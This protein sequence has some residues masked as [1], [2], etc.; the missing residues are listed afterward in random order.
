MASQPESGSGAG[1]E[2]GSEAL[3]TVIAR[4][5]LQRGWVTRQQIVQC[6]R[7][8]GAAAPDR[9]GGTGLADLLVSKGLISRPQ[10]AIVDGEA[11]RLIRAGAY[12]EA[13]QEAGLGD[14]LVRMG[15][16]TQS[17]VQ[18]ALS[19]Q[20]EYA[21]RRELVP[22]LGEILLQ[23]G[24]V[25]SAALDEALRLQRTMTRLRCEYCATD[26][27]LAEFD[28]GKTYLCRGCASVL[29]RPRG[30][31]AARAD[32]PE[33]AQRAATNPKNVVGKY[34]AVKELG[35]GGMGAVYKA[36]D[37]VLKRWAALKILAV[38]GGPEAV[39]RFRREAETASQ[40]VHPNIVP[41][42]DVGEAGGYHYIAMQYIDGRQLGEQ[43]LPV[44]QACN[45]IIQVAR[46]IELAH[47][48]D[49]VHRDIK[50]QNILI[51]ASGR[52]YVTD[53]GLAKNLFESFNI[54]APGTVMGS[55]SY[56]SPEQAAGQVSKVDQRS[57]VYSLGALLFTLLTGRPPYKAET[58]VMTVR[59]VLE[60]PIPSPTEFNPEIPPELERIVMRALDRDKAR[61]YPSAGP[62]ADDLERFLKGEPIPTAEP[63]PE[64]PAPPPA[65]PPPREP[66]L[67]RAAVVAIVILTLAALA[68]LLAAILRP[69]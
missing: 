2:T 19:V 17:Q 32:E 58:A 21:G 13:R 33:E 38:A 39:I 37:T 45:L 53:F 23:K 31:A 50:P 64:R 65:P 16:I 60:T 62:F 67:R 36:W 51:D 54:T 3:W 9:A 15:R 57:D 40:L 10:A 66:R 22:L 5:C 25:D 34:V 27:L 35:R 12:S 55:P 7:E 69:A 6:L 11:K 4:I 52:P 42:Y 29:C 24:H 48:K 18:E 1:P 30:P 41:I 68:V 20:A 28:P 26:Y 63:P 47:S 14:L 59:M 56:M 49:I 8:R 61:R 44:E 46:A 43:K